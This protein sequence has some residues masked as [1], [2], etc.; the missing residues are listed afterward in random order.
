MFKLMEK[1]HWE[2]SE[3][4]VLCIVDFV[5]D[6]IAGVNVSDASDFSFDKPY[7]RE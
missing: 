3:P 5:R 2:K 6:V 4:I 1:H 7:P